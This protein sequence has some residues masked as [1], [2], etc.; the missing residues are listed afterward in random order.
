[1]V[2]TE[3]INATYITS[4]W[5]NLGQFIYNKSRCITSVSMSLSFYSHPLSHFPFPFYFTFFFLYLFS[6]L[7]LFHYSKVSAQNLKLHTVIFVFNFL[8][9][10]F[11]LWC[12]KTTKRKRAIRNREVKSRLSEMGK[13]IEM[14]RSRDV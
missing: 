1:M 11:G 2:K 12:R 4:N 9:C 8:F 5:H 3:I 7:S 13:S 10:E 14:R 6:A